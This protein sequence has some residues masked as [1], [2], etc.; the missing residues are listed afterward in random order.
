MELQLLLLMISAWK[1]MDW[2][3]NSRMSFSILM[4]LILFAF[5]ELFQNTPDAMLLLYQFGS[6]KEASM[7]F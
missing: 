4:F 3:L 6:I 5:L 1:E 2:Y 7:I